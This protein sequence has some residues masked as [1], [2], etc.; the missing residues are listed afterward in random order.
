MQTCHKTERDGMREVAAILARGFVRLELSRRPAVFLRE[1]PQ[2]P[3]A[4]SSTESPDVCDEGRHGEQ[5]HAR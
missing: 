5:E 3:V 1:E 4:F 2:I